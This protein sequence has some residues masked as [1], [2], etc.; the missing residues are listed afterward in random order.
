[1]K[2]NEFFLLRFKIKSLQFLKWYMFVNFSFS[3]KTLILK[4]MAIR[5]AKEMEEEKQ[6]QTAELEMKNWTIKEEYEDDFL[7]NISC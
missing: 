6:K 5:L 1:M 3:G 2:I 7:K 4:E